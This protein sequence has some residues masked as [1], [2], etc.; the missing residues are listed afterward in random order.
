[1]KHEEL[2][3]AYAC[4]ASIQFWSKVGNHWVDIPVPSWLEESLYRI[5]PQPQ[6]ETKMTDK[7]K[8]LIEAFKQGAK[9]EWFDEAD[10][11]WYDVLNP[12]WFENVN[13][14][15]KPQPQ[16]ETNKHVH[17]D[18]IK[19]WADGAKIQVYIPR[20][21]TWIDANPSWDPKFQYRVKPEPVV[22]KAYMHY[23][24]IKRLVT[25]RFDG[26]AVNQFLHEDSCGM[27]NHLE[28]TFVD[29]ELVS[30]NINKRG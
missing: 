2:K 29:G 10:K 15:I 8:E 28:F 22:K 5:K 20:S 27:S 11:K 6:Q 26:K 14:R 16:Q 25:G 1:M 17:A 18:M 21:D 30:V 13:Y 3:Y 9:I 19:A 7:H 4:G 24:N 23:D 12:S